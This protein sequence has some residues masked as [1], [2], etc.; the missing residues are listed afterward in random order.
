L[1]KAAGMDLTDAASA[2]T[3]AMNQMGISAKDATSIIDG[4]A[5]GA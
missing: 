5:T 1:S 3:T 2:I 4:L